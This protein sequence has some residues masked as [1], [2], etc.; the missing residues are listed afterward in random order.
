MY[1]GVN[2]ADTALIQGKRQWKSK[3]TRIWSKENN[4]NDT[5]D[6]SSILAGLRYIYDGM[7]YNVGID[8]CWWSSTETDVK[9]IWVRKSNY[10]FDKLYPFPDYKNSGFSI[11]CIKDH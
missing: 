4:G 2:Q 8:G 10:Y 3:I 11:R 5:S 7:F 6:F 9:L 1:L